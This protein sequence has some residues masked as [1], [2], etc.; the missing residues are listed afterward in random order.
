MLLKDR[1][2]YDKTELGGRCTALNTYTRKGHIN[3]PSLHLKN[4]EK[5]E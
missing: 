5:E 4:L 1:I 2:P 3:D